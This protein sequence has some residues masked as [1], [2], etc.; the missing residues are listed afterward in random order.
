[1]SIEE[2]KKRNPICYIMVSLHLRDEV[3]K[4]VKDLGIRETGILVSCSDYH[5]FKK[6]KKTRK[7][8]MEGYLATVAQAFEAGVMP[9]CRIRPCAEFASG[10]LDRFSERVQ[11]R[12]VDALRLIV[13]LVVE[14][15][16][17]A[18]PTGG[19]IIGR[20]RRRR[21]GNAGGD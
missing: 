13:A 15:P 14:V 12:G 2:L 10:N 3:Y 4:F 9:R 16:P 20:G 19:K 17:V 5:I 8:A 6:L 7:E 21:H 18:G 11:S 1:M